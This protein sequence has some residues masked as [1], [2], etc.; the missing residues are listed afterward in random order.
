MLRARYMTYNKHIDLYVIIYVYYVSIWGFFFLIIKKLTSCRGMLITRCERS[1][2]EVSWRISGARAE[3][4]ARRTNNCWRGER[5]V[6][7]RRYEFERPKLL[8]LVLQP[9]VFLCQRLATFFPL[10]VI[11]LCLLQLIS[12]HKFSRNTYY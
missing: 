11:R 2:Y 7:R 1:G 8:Q 10:L 3:P 5:R 4:L 6:K 9:L 12:A